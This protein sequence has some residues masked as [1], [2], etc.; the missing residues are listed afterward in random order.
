MMLM[1]IQEQKQNLIENQRQIQYQAKLQA[2]RT[3]ARQACVRKHNHRSS[4]E[5]AD[6]LS[7]SKIKLDQAIARRNTA[8]SL[9]FRSFSTVFV[10][11]TFV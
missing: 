9:L 3:V 8:L 6:K 7:D 2:Q 10:L 1:S 4:P 11:F 5:Y